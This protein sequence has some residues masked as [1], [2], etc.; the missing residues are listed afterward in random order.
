[1]E[2]KCPNGDTYYFYLE[3]CEIEIETKRRALCTKLS[4]SWKPHI[5]TSICGT[6]WRE[7][8]ECYGIEEDDVVKFT[9]NEDHHVFNVEVTNKHNAA[10]PFVQHTGMLVCVLFLTH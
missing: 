6:Q 7:L 2:A 5:H 3:R 1:M 10:K 8:C 9:W 4:D